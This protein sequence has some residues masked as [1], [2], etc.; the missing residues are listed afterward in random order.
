D[1]FTKIGQELSA[2]KPGRFTGY[3]CDAQQTQ[4]TAII[5]GEQ[6]LSEAAAGDT[7]WLTL[8]ETPFYGESGGQV[9]DRGCLTGDEGLLVEIKDTQKLNNGLTVHKFL[10]KQ[11]MLRPGRQVVAKISA[12]RRQSIARN[13]SAT[14]LL[15]RALRLILGE[16]VHQAGSLV[17][18]SRLRFDFHHPE[19][20]TA[21]QLQAV[22]HEVHRLILANLPVD[23]REMP[24]ED[25]KATGAMAFFGDKY[26][27]IVRLVSMGEESRELCGGTHCRYTGDIGAFKIIAESGIG[28]GMRRIEALT[29]WGAI[30]Y[31]R[32]Q[33]QRLNHLAAMLKSS[34]Q[35]VEKRLE[36][37][38]AENKAQAK[39]LASLQAKLVKNNTADLWRNALEIDGVKVLAAEVA[40]A[41]MP[42]LRNIMDRMRD[43]LPDAAIVLAAPHEDKVS[44]V[45]S[46]SLA[47]QAKGL[48]AG[49]LIKEVAAVCGGSGGGRPDMAQAG[50]KDT[51]K[52]AEALDLATKL[53]T[54]ALN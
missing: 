33:E 43:K 42:A 15:H 8:A 16:H 37:L 6:R 44:F 40:A 48:H 39:E 52:I 3:H 9:G 12:E 26:G 23:D 29:G 4:I 28:S 10:V 50:G 35:Q 54:A 31:Y 14:H 5:S 53:I 11:G 24:L 18:D 25:A 45:V 27:D 34:P 20:L 36:T 2:I 21:E 41:D 7:G 19:P 32:G 49:K 13:H 1:N 22:E 30:D 51:S 17:T 47:A 46:I 38:I